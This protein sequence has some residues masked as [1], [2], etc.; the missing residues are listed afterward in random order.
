MRVFDPLV[1][2]LVDVRVGFVLIQVFVQV[3]HGR[4][5]SVARPEDEGLIARVPVGV[6][7]IGGLGVRAA[8]E[9]R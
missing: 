6:D 8:D 5:V 7:Q 4:E 3:R 9:H 2:R 1:L